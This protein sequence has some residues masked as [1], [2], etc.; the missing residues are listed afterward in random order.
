VLD[1]LIHD[2]L[3]LSK[4]CLLAIGHISATPDLALVDMIVND[5]KG[6][7]RLEALL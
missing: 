4:Q 2:H 3:D 1:G 7:E 6:F 5:G